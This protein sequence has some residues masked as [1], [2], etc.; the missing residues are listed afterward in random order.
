MFCFVFNL[1]CVH[2]FLHVNRLPDHPYIEML[3][4]GMFHY[5]LDNMHTVDCHGVMPH[6]AGNVLKV[7]I[8]EKLPGTPAQNLGT[9]WVRV[10]ELYDEF[11]IEQRLANLSL[12]I[13][14]CFRYLLYV[15]GFVRSF[16]CSYTCMSVCMHVSI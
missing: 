1:V 13:P 2:L 6:V 3:G 5:R 8:Y 16:I 14:S 4:V 15:Q 12:S 11:N 10:Q 7:L 9:V